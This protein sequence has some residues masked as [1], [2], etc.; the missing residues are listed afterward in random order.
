[1]KR[2]LNLKRLFNKRKLS[3]FMK[4]FSKIRFRDLKKLSIMK[5]FLNLKVRSKLLI[6]FVAIS[7]YISMVGISSY[8]SMKA[9]NKGSQQIYNHNL[10]SIQTL[11]Q[12]QKNVISIQGN[13][14]VILLK[15]N[16][17]VSQVKID[18]VNDVLKENSKLILKYNELNSNIA[19]KQDENNILLNSTNDTCTKLIVGLL[20]LISENKYD[21]TDDLFQTFSAASSNLDNNLQ[22]LII[23]NEESANITNLDNKNLFIKSVITIVII[24]LSGFIIAIILGILISALI[25]NGL[26]KSV[27]FAENLG[28]GNLTKTLD[29]NLNDEVGILSK[30]LNKACSNTKKLV[31]SIIEQ[32][33]KVNAYSRDIFNSTEEISADIQ[34]VNGS[35]YKINSGINDINL[36]VNGISDLSQEILSSIVLVYNKAV[37]TSSISKGIKERATNVKNITLKSKE[38]VNSIY[39]EKQANILKAIENG[40]VVKDIEVMSD[41]IDNIAKQTKLLSLNASIEAARAGEQGKGFAVVAKEIGKLASLSTNATLDIKNTVNLVEKAFSYIGQSSNEI[42]EFIDNN[43]IK[44]YDLMLDMGNDYQSDSEYMNEFSDYLV[45][46][47]TDIKNIIGKTNTSIGS[48]LE[49]LLE[50]TGSSNQIAAS[51]S[52]TSKAMEYIVSGHQNQANQGEDLH[53]LVQQFKI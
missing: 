49:L 7:L 53:K 36:A 50:V 4:L 26:N 42:L 24:T 30:A 41:L 44:D 34:M 40:K 3:E 13:L 17:T 51:V 9:I 48:V 1:M 2:F 46:S 8:V 14:E 39:I 31:V 5:R 18:K 22:N 37:D 32:V 16:A 19:N 15:K 10:V 12:I 33:N 20:D 35:T 28:E 52:E 43:I 45:G 47:T 25:A 23:T 21:E 11:G 38:M 27:D 29:I 6:C